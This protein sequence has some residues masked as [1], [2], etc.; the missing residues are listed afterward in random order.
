MSR[1]T[2]APSAKPIPIADP[3]LVGF[4]LSAMPE[5]NPAACRYG[6]RSYSVAPRY[7]VA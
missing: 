2:P 3:E 5:R 4:F 7:P 1:P 6:D